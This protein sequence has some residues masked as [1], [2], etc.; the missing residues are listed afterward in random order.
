VK[1]LY[2]RLSSIQNTLF[3]LR[4]KP[5]TFGT[6]QLFRERSLGKISKEEFRIRRDSSFCCVGKKQGINLNL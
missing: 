2:S 1:G 4:F 6:K 5:I 3:T